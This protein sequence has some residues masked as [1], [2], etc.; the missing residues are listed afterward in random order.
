MDPRK[1]PEIWRHFLP[2]EQ[3]VLKKCAWTATG[4]GALGLVAAMALAPAILR[5]S[6][7]FR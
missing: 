5:F 2:E 1:L 4:R 7:F 6:I 3:D